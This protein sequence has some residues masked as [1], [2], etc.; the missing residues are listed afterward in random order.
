[1]AEQRGPLTLDELDRLVEKMLPTGPNVTMYFSLY[2]VE[3]IRRA[4][5]PPVRLG[6]RHWT[7]ATGRHPRHVSRER[8]MRCV[9]RQPLWEAADA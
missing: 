4:S 2:I 9:M 3:R 5:L 8:G 7:C 6:R 1:M